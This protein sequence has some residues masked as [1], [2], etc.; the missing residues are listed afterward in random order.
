MNARFKMHL[1]TSVT[2][3][4]SPQTAPSSG[5]PSIS[6]RRRP[7]SRSLPISLLKP[8]PLP[9]HASFDCSH[10]TTK[11]VPCLVATTW[12]TVLPTKGTPVL[13]PP[14]RIAPT[15]D[16]NELVGETLGFTSPK[17]FARQRREP[18]TPGPQVW[19]KAATPLLLENRL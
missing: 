5:S 16:Q 17:Q 10:L 6:Y 8:L 1:D 11:L 12:P 15:C 14:V 9:C 2:F 4:S 18:D 19:A 7:F 3:S 13:P